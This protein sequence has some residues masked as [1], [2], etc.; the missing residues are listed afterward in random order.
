MIKHIHHERETGII[1]LTTEHTLYQMKADTTGVL[2]HLYY[3][4]RS[5]GCLDYLLSFAD[6]GFSGNP[7]EAGD[8]R[9][10]SMDALPQEFPAQG[11]GIF[12][13]RDRGLPP[14]FPSGSE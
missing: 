9:S 3:G 8:E 11:T 5:E 12:R 6:R 10:Y 2:L 13:G 7:Y 14:A 1:S 4:Q